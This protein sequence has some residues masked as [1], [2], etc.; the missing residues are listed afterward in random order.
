M[1]SS[2]RTDEV[3]DGDDCPYPEEVTPQ[4]K[5]GQV[6]HAS[7]EEHSPS[8]AT[9]TGHDTGGIVDAPSRSEVDS[10][11]PTPSPEATVRI[12]RWLEGTDKYSEALSPTAALAASYRVQNRYEGVFPVVVDKKVSDNDMLVRLLLDVDAS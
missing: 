9:L 3:D 11:A 8:S 6:V 1:D 4:G 5:G 10:V 2:P 12:T 7:D